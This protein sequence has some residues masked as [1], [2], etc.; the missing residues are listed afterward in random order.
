MDIR[1]M[2][3]RALRWRCA[4]AVAGLACAA[5]VSTSATAS[6][7]TFQQAL[8]RARTDAPSLEARQRQVRAARSAADAADALPDPTL[9]LSLQNV[10]VSGPEAFSLGA[11]FMTMQTIGI[12]Q[13]FPNAAKRHARLGRAEANIAAAEA[14]VAVE[15]RSVRVATAL[16]W[17]DLYFAEQ[18]LE[19]L[20]LLDKSIDALAGTVGARITSGSARPSQGLEP[21]QLRA[22]LADRRSDIEAEI[23]KAKAELTRWTGDPDPQVVGA[24]PDWAID[25]DRLIATVDALPRLQAL[26]AATAQAEAD[27]RLARA[28][29]RPDWSVNVGYSRRGPNYADMVSVGVSIDLPLFAK[30]RQDPVIAARAE[31][32]NAARLERAA[33]EREMRAQIESDLAEHRAH[34][35]R[36]MRAKNTLVPL[37]EQRA[38]LD[39]ES[40]AAGRIDLG[41]AL[42]AT[43][44]LANAR[45]DALDR[46]A[47]AA[48]DGIRINL[49]YGR[50]SQ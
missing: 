35:E 33:A 5:F 3:Q 6:P 26:D 2:S 29:K 32:A 38:E 42:D 39:R 17:T 50:I 27:V 28:E 49:T 43:I 19:I 23:A 9:D 16:A 40:Y 10:P 20:E 4:F 1:I 31:E 30:H 46:E 34:H 48:R 18:R 14:S 45:I 44:A 25:P 15:A 12:R 24:P 36:Y 13:A 37:A 8:D 7:L 47:M 21:R 22:E 11:D 41:T